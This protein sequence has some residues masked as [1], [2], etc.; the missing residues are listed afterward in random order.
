MP[1][2]DPFFRAL[3]I[4]STA[5]GRSHSFYFAPA[6]CLNMLPHAEADSMTSVSLLS[7]LLA[8]QVSGEDAEDGFEG[9]G[10]SNPFLLK[11]TRDDSD[12]WLW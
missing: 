3:L 9:R 4:S 10:F 6:V 12:S 7:I 8:K 11:R 2:Y 1:I 5:G